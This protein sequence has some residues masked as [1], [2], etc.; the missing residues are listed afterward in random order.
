MVP[1]WNPRLSALLSAS[2]G[3]LLLVAT[4]SIGYAAE[5]LFQPDVF[6]AYTLLAIGRAA[7]SVFLECALAGVAMVATVGWVERHAARRSVLY[8]SQLAAAA[9][10]GSFVG[11]AI[12][13]ALLQ[14][15]VSAEAMPF[16]LGEVLRLATLGAFLSLVHGLGQRIRATRA[17]EQELALEA[18]SLR[19]ETEL[20][21]LR[22]LEAQIEPHFLFN[23][24]A[25]VRRTW[26]VDEALGR[27]MHDNAIRCLEASLP[28]V[29]A[30]Q[31]LLADEID[32]T[33]AYLELFA[34]RM[35]PRLRY[36]IDM[37]ATL[38]RWPFPRMALLTLV[39]NSIKHG[40][41]PSDDG[42]TIA[43]AAALDNGDLLV[44]VVDDGIGFGGADT[45]GSGIGL[46]NIRSRL[47]AEYG[48]RARLEISS[49]AIGGVVASIRIPAHTSQTAFLDEARHRPAALA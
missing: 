10:L 7:G 23:T 42:G 33:R 37:P 47:A 2:R 34:L 28:K 46:I 12:W 49:A 41:M 29:R 16:L 4:V 14:Q 21:Q 39:E 25:N 31:S 6:N 40:L 30:T 38:A 36:T 9:V 24:I 32:L 26:R 45:S 20:S 35:G 48:R 17:R 43:V 44:R 1:A 8:A 18:E 5:L 15:P 22:L 19:A 11:I 13:S 3:R 27:R